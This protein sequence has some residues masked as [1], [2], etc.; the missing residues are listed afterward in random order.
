MRPS[1]RTL[2]TN[3]GT[4]VATTTFYI[5]GQASGTFVDDHHT[6]GIADLVA[7]KTTFDFDYFFNGV[8]DEL[9]I[10]NKALTATELKKRYRTWA[11]S[12]VADN[13]SGGGVNVQAGDRVTIIFDAETNAD[14]INASNIDTALALNNSHSW[15]DGSGAIGSAVW[16]T[17]TN[18]NDTL[19]ITLSDTTSVRY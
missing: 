1:R 13:N 10:Y 14:T 5:N 17:T 11:T 19:T 12:S 9:V 2:S 6:G 16:S 3:N 8:V 7:G 4:L 18:T 15:K